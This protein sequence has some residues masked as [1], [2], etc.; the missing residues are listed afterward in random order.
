MRV[1]LN[2]E[3]V[4]GRTNNTHRESTTGSSTGEA[5]STCAPP[6]GRRAAPEAEHGFRVLV[7]VW[8]P[9]SSLANGALDPRCWLDVWEQGWVFSWEVD[10][11]AWDAFPHALCTLEGEGPAAE[12]L[13]VSEIQS[14]SPGLWLHS[15][16]LSGVTGVPILG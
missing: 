13:E 11:T 9:S 7:W 12:T 10:W 6:T 14:V 3:A 1:N 16:M 15:T 4:A 2:C 5:P 8:L